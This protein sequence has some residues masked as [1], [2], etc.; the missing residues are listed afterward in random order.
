MTAANFLFIVDTSILATANLQIPLCLL[1]QPQVNF[2]MTN[3]TFEIPITWK[4]NEI[5]FAAKLIPTGYITRIGIDI[6]GEEVVLEPDEEGQYRVVMET[7]ASGNYPEIDI[8]LVREIA[9]VLNTV[10]GTD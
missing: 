8:P 3:D 9:H 1:S 10:N 4:G 2:S 6:Y 5:S 7:D